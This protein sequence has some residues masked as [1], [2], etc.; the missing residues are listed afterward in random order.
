MSRAVYVGS[1]GNGRTS[2]EKVATS[3]EVYYDDVDF[4]T[5]SE[6]I[7][8]QDTVNRAS[9]GVD[10]VTHGAGALLLDSPEAD[11]NIAVLL[12]PP[13]PTTARELVASMV[14]KTL[15]MGIDGANGLES[16]IE[17]SASS[18]FEVAVS[19]LAN[20]S[21]IA[22]VARFNSA[23]AAYSALLR[24]VDSYLFWTENDQCYGR[25]AA[26]VLPLLS[27]R[28]PARILPGEHDEVVLR[29]DQFLP[30]VFRVVDSQGIF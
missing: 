30:Q 8:D 18:A 16:M 4:F 5:F 7:K 26:D 23:D 24:G 3:L 12:C 17:Y 29:P 19:P 6:A 20:I 10:L 14:K 11:P 1:I 28:L 21:N 22:R 27:R 9:A 15:L 2:A 25:A 13:L